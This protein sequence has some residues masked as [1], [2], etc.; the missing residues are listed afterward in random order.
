MS[1]RPVAAP[2]AKSVHQNRIIVTRSATRSQCTAV[3]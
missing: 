2:K 3:P 1:M